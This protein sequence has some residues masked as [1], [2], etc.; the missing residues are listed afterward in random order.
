VR[1]ALRAYADGPPDV[2]VS[3]IGMPGE[4]GY[5][6]IGAIRDREDGTTRRT[7]AIAISGFA[8]RGDHETALRAGFDDHLGKPVEPAALVQ[9][10]LVL[11]AARPSTTS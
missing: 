9:C 11:A 10:V 5:T 6:L 4:D 7:L 2:L 8:T 1:E 3:D